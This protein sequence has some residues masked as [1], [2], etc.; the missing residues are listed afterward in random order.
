MTLI[1]TAIKKLTQSDLSL[2]KIHLKL[3]KQKA[4]NLNSNIFIELYFPSLSNSFDNIHLP[5]TIIGP[6][7]REQH[8]LSRKILRSQGSKNWRLNGEFIHNPEEDSVRY[9]SLCPDDYA[10]LMFEGTERPTAITMILVSRSENLDL[11]ALIS[12]EI[13]FIGKNTMV[14]ISPQKLIDIFENRTFSN[15]ITNALDCINSF[16]ND[17]IEDVLYGKKRFE[18]VEQRSTHSFPRLTHEQ[19]QRQMQVAQE[20][21]RFGEE[22]FRTWLLDNGQI[23]EK[24]KWTLNESARSPYDYEILSPFWLPQT[25][26]IYLDVKTTRS[27]FDQPFHMSYSEIKFASLCDNYRIARIF[28]LDLISKKICILN[29]IS[30]LANQLLDTFSALPKEV[31]VDSISLVPSQFQIE[32]ESSIE[33]LP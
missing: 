32:L 10:V 29:G 17:T 22:I 13:Q 8:T 15:A 19:L 2:F 27:N 3:S 31:G 11:H 7:D 23:E 25:E 28:N 16:N 20:T 21:G 26:K 12:T 30:E 24:F 5:L 18:L 9:N 14:D 1:R 6:G 33:Y 4:I